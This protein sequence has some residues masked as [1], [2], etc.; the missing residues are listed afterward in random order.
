MRRTVPDSL[1]RILLTCLALALAV[2]LPNPTSTHAQPRAEYRAFWV[3]TFNTSLNTPAQV[4]AVI[5]NA[6]LAKANALVVQ[7]R[8]RGDSWYLNSLEPPADRTPIAPGFDPLQELINQAH[9]PENN[10]EVHAFVIV[11]AVWN[12]DPR[13]PTLQPPAGHVFL[14]NGG[15]SG[16][17]GNIAPG[18]NN[19]LTRTMLPDSVSPHP[20]TCQTGTPPAISFN[21]HRFGAEFWID[22]GH[23]DAAAYTNKVLMHLVQSYDLDGLHLDRIRYPE[24]TASGQT[25]SN[26][27]NIGYNE[28]S[29][30]RFNARFGR[31]GTPAQNDPQW[32]Q[33]RRDQVTNFVRRLYLDVVAIKPQMKLSGA[34]IAFGG[35]P[36]TEAGWNSA[37]AYWR[38]YQDWRAWTEEGITDIA[39]PMDYKRENSVAPVNQPLQFDQWSEWLKNHQ[40][41]RAGVV[42]QGASLNS[43]EGTLRQTR[44]A[45]APSAATGNSGIG[46]IFFSMA[47]NNVPVAANPHSLPPGQNTP[48]RSFAEFASGLT[49]GKSVNGATLYEPAGQTPIF[50]ESATIP[51]LPWKSAPTVGHVRG[52]A[53]RADGTPLDTA[54]VTIENLGTG[55]TRNTATD[56][57]GFFGGVDLAPGEYLVKV[58]HGADVLY[59]C[60]T[61]VTAGNVS[62]ADAGADDAAPVTTATLNP[63]APNGSN[64]WYTSDV[65]VTLDASDSCTGVA[66]TEYSADGGATWQPYAGVLAVTQEGTTTILY[67]SADRAG[68]VETARSLT[69]KI[70]KT[71]P[72]VQL[73]A[74]PSII[75]GNNGKPFAVTLSGVGADGVSGLANISY[76]VTDE[77]GAPLGIQTRTLVGQSAAWA[78]TLNV[79][80]RRN[81]NDL[82]G[83]RYLVTATI[84]DA[85]G[86]T[87]TA[88]AEILVPHDQR[89]N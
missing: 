26:G 49:T 84:T 40:Y 11:A 87:S 8:R 44:R 57:G 76:V 30:A 68:N 80:A 37:E 79:E 2:L 28:T 81:G 53:K 45:L 86:H 20:T 18:P 51:V 23:P 82:D 85:A 60:V 55:A 59:S 29:V 36:T 21:G 83:R 47:T 24:F 65:A 89:D 48:T 34:Y 56:G 3:D 5:N 67:R 15:F 31:T 10:M 43:I 54:N 19:W 41:N 62:T 16:A 13:C 7:V 58:E 70:D 61:T 42:G 22:L 32:S 39:M 74:D 4:L 25:P 73:S 66:G 14:S 88:E 69:V 50:S 77:Y 35:G 72:T 71:A 27:A 6:K 17:T 12:R 63:A 1:T 78:E 64:G 75:R 33:W 46:V 38:V 9:K 52:F